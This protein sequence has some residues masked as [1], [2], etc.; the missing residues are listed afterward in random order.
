MNLHLEPQ[1]FLGTGASLLA[2]ISL[3]AYILLIVPGMLAG[4]VF[5][6]RGQHR[7]QHK[8]IMTSI[9]IINW[10][11][12]IF[13]MVMSYRYDVA[14][15]I[16]QQPTNTQ[17]LLPTLHAILGLPAQLLATYIVIGMLREDSQVA[18]AKARGE[19]NLQK[20][21][22]RNAKSK[23]RVALTLWLATAALGILTYLIRYEVIPNTVLGGSV[24]APVATEDIP[25]PESTEE[26]ATPEATND[27]AAPEAT[28]PLETPEATQDIPIPAPAATDELS[29]LEIEASED[30]ADEAEDA[31]RDATRD[32]EDRAEDAT[33]AAE[34]A[35]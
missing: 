33:K 4:A 24:P 23:M 22:F 20:Y 26:L 21:W 32:A 6:R 1:G 12:I 15:N 35:S 28:E 9:T 19:T 2:D 27:I 29:E 5:A 31:A 10:L 7:P 3:L 8:W 11:L 14:Q 17:Y 25:A 13:L 18:R 16:G 30:A 34:D